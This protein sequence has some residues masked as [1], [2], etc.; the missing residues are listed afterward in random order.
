VATV[1]FG[2][3]RNVNTI[4]HLTEAAAERTNIVVH[5]RRVVLRVRNVVQIPLPA[6]LIAARA[7]MSAV[8]GVEGCGLNVR[9]A[10]T[11]LKIMCPT[12]TWFTVD[13]RPY[14]NANDSPFPVP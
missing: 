9:Q 12:R 10:I 6:I 4:V 5:I 11:K 8:K 2:T 1:S 14:Q 7:V 3:G 13:M